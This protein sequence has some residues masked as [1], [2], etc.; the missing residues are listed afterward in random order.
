MS[1]VRDGE[2][3]YEVYKRADRAFDHNY[4]LDPETYFVIRSSDLFGSAAL[5]GYAHLL[6]T[7]IEIARQRPGTFTDEECERLKTLADDLAKKAEAWAVKGGRLP[8]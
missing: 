8:D 1:F 3:K 7:G 2:M 5:W 6:Q 4:M